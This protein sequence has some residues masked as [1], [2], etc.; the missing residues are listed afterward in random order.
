MPWLHNT[1]TMQ[2]YTDNESDHESDYA[3][4]KNAFIDKDL[5]STLFLS[6]NNFMASHI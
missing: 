6:L 5:T 3:L 2:D 1:H 4:S